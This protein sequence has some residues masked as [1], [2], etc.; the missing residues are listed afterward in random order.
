MIKVIFDKN[1]IPS[2]D[3]KILKEVKDIIKEGR[4]GL[5]I[6]HTS[7][8][9]IVYIL[10]EAMQ[11]KIIS[12]EEIEFYTTI[13][14]KELIIRHNEEGDFIDSMPSPASELF[15]ITFSKSDLSNYLK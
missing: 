6:V 1:G 11:N 5:K 13:D 8:E 9:N 14:D 3:F 15:D 10:K 2:N 4:K 7:S 12:P